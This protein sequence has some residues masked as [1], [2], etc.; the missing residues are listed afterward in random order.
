[1]EAGNFKSITKQTYNAI[2]STVG[3]T[4]DDYF[5]ACVKPEAD[6]FVKDLPPNGRILDI[7]CGAGT[8]L[9]YFNE[10][11]Y[12]VTG[13]DISEEMVKICQ[14]QNLPAVVGDIET[15]MFPED[16]F[17]GIWAHTSLIHF[18]KEQLENIII[19]ICRFLKPA[20][21]LF[22]AVR[23]GETDGY[24]SF[25]GDAQL[26]RYFSNFGQGELSDHIPSNMKLQ[27]S[28]RTEFKDRGF[29]NY[30]FVKK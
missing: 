24:E 3:S 10:L 30:H 18:P 7:G 13:I 9:K 14:N 26:Q 6:L 21:K 22:I 5:L 8:H 27:S 15:I 4:Y 16:H 29:L 28:S 25:R 19:G 11:G 17:D 12:N 2:A 20:G 23:E 1:M